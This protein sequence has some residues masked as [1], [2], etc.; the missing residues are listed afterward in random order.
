VT[1]PR[2][3]LLGLL[4][5]VIIAPTA[6]GDVFQP[7]SGAGTF[8]TP[9]GY[10]GLDGRQSWEI[11]RKMNGDAVVTAS[12]V[13]GNGTLAEF[14]NQHLG[15]T[16]GGGF[17]FTGEVFLGKTQATTP[18][19]DLFY[20]KD[21]TLNNGVTT[22]PSQNY[23]ANLHTSFDIRIG[24]VQNA[25]AYMTA[26]GGDNKDTDLF[27]ELRGTNGVYFHLGGGNTGATTQGQPGNAWNISPNGGGYVFGPLSLSENLL[28]PTPVTRTLIT[29]GGTPTDNGAAYNAPLELSAKLMADPATP[30]NVIAQAKAGNNLYQFSFSPTDLSFNGTFD[31]ERATPIIFIGK[32]A[33]DSFNPANGHMGI[34]APGDTDADGTVGFSDLVAVAQHY[35]SADDPSW[36]TGDL[37]GDGLVSFADL[38]MVA[39]HYGQTVNVPAGAAS[40]VPEPM[41]LALVAVFTFMA[42]G[43][44][45]RPVVTPPRFATKRH[46]C[47]IG[48]V[49]GAATFTAQAAPVPAISYSGA[50]AE[51]FGGGFTSVGYQ[52]TTSSP[53][54]ISAL[55]I[56]DHGGNDIPATGWDAGLYSTDP[57]H[58]L[59]TSATVKSSDSLTSPAG[60]GP[61]LFRYHALTSPYT[62]PAGTYMLASVDPS[63]WFNK[64]ATGVTTGTDL[65]TITIDH[66]TY[67]GLGA[68]GQP[69]AYPDNVFDGN[70]PGNF[71]PNFL[72]SPTPEPA[73]IGLI[74]FSV[75]LIASRRR[76]GLTHA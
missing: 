46:L 18:A 15:D 17:N 42:L 29:S 64:V 41:S 22:P 74:L 49:I 48:L 1:Y 2:A 16:P 31:W 75:A 55:G 14:T 68:G 4:L 76:R 30:G 27:G 61:D 12:S 37:N 66:A 53:L 8:G 69:L 7:A 23:D 67:A 38:V 11:Y 44:R 73:S 33:F 58:T 50:A 34:L 24:F 36:S 13:S 59:L 21:M 40:D 60:G 63:G 54:S 62:L 19:T 6:R 28:V 57:S 71:G 65:G 70:L 52:F 10:L 51:Q 72:A 56:F 47:G 9:Y 39:Q 3:F 32:G 45:R 43:L 5:S 25:S 35:G 26:K 20:L